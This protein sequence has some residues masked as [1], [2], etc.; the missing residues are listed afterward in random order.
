MEILALPLESRVVVV[1]LGHE[2]YRIKKR[3]RQDS[4]Y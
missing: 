3:S 2:Q 1:Y 4:R